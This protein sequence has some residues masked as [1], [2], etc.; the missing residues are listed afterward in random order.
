MTRHH[1]ILCAALALSGLSMGSCTRASEQEQHTE[2]V[3]AEQNLSQ[4]LENYFEERLKLFPL[5]ATAIADSRY[6]DQLPNDISQAHRQQVRELYQKYLEA[7]NKLDRSKLDEQE[8]VSY[9]IFRYE[10]QTA[11]EGLEQPWS[12]LPINQFWGTTLTMAQLGSG[13]SNQPF[14][15]PKDYRDFLGRINDF[16]VWGD[17][18]IANMRRG[19]VAGVTLPRALSQKVLPQLKAMVVDNPEKSIFWTPVTKMP[20]SFTAA[21]K[22]SI[23]QAY[24]KAITEVVVPTYKKLHDFVEQ[25]Y[26]PKSRTTTGISEIKGGDAFYRYLVRYWTTTDL[27]PDQI[28]E[29][30][31]QEVAR[32]RGEMEKVKEQVGFKGDLKAFFKHIN[33]NQK[34]TPYKTPEQVLAA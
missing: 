22:D 8:Q 6:N 34:F 33:E 18:A 17:T 23:R 7:V 2:A 29:I 27:T 11:L 30:G 19:M 3:Q 13:A 5:E 21:Q 24:T 1:L 32:I 10:M 9:D 15:T 16:S 25:E 31:Q 12:L 4:L 28:F 20:D 14:K 26:L